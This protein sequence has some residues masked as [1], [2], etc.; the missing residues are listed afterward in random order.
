MNRSNAVYGEAVVDIHVSHV[1]A[2]LIVDDLYL[3]IA[4]F[5]SN[6]GGQ[7]LDDRNELRNHLFQI[8][9]RPFFQSLCQ[10]GVVGVCAGLA[11]NLDC[12]VHCKRFIVY[13][14]TDQLRNNHGRMGIVDLDDCII[15]HLSQ[16]VLLFLH[17]HQDQL[18]S[19]ADHEILLINTKQ[20]AGFIGIIG[21]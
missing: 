6:T 13:Q 10:N 20:V 3:R 1:H 17:L 5:C 18:C 7:L 9:Q 15:V 4:V 21:I 12:L 16:I 19:V 14:D 2:V 8:G 11:D